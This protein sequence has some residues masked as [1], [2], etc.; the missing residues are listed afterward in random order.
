MARVDSSIFRAADI[1][2]RVN[3]T[4]LTVSTVEL[5]GL[6]Y[7]TLLAHHGIDRVVVGYDSR[8]FSPGFSQA[9]IAGLRAS[10]CDVIH[11]GLVTT[12]MVY[13]AQ[14]HLRSQGAVMIT[15]SH[16]PPEWS[17]FKMA[18][19]YSYTIVGDEVQE[20]RKFIENDRFVRGAGALTEEDVAEAYYADLLSRV[21]IKRHFKVVVDAGNGTAGKYMPELYRRAGCEVVELFCD[22]DP[23]FPNHFPD[24][25]LVESRIAISDEVRRTGADL[26]LSF[27]GDGDR[28]GVNDERGETV[29][30]DQLL[31]LWSRDV[32][33]RHPGANIVFDT[34]CSQGLI[35]EILKNGGVPIMCRTGH[36]FIKAKY[37]ET[38]A[39]LAGEMSGHL[40]FIERFYGVD[41]AGYAGLR[42]LEYLADRGENLSRSV[43]SLPVYV[44]SPEG[45]VACPDTAKY[46]VASDIAKRF[47]S[48]GLE[49]S[50][51][52]GARVTFAD[53]WG[54]V[55]AS[56]NLPMLTLRFE[57]RTSEA[58]ERIKCAFKT[59]LDNYP[60][61]SKTWENIEFNPCLENGE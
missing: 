27:D 2:G 1:R 3:D 32:L 5:I 30:S 55:R 37:K 15:G 35:D 14:Y 6:G 16:N 42:L 9:L 45:R 54:A 28:L 31:A 29:W 59:K 8:V 22:L 61:V 21:D 46:L 18:R 50:E 49:V 39:V 23:T 13:W 17:G 36:P 33:V 40:F 38:G 7:G 53:G 43:A 41:D 57:G 11:L 48:E 19:G 44:S 47:A 26:G 20:I 12:P 60:E 51:I 56:S 24:P 58:L 25:A 34:K 52:D 10:G 4:E